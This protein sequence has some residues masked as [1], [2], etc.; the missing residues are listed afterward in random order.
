MGT[1]RCVGKVLGGPTCRSTGG[2]AANDGLSEVRFS[3]GMPG[4]LVS[5]MIAPLPSSKRVPKSD[6]TAAA[7]AK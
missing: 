6:A 4:S 1:Q 3:A 2:A 5:V 7:A